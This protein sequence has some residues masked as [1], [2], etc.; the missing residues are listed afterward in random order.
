MSYKMEQTMRW[1][2]PNDP[3]SLRDILQSG[4]TGIVTAL[5]H[6][7]N[8]EVWSREEIKKRK[9]TIEAAG[10]TWS[11][12]ESV[13]VHEV[14][15][16]RSGNYQ[17][18]IE[19]YKETIRNLA[20]EGIYT[21]CYNFMPILDWT[22]TDL[23]REL[24]NGV[25]ALHYEKKAVQAFDLFILKRAEAEQEYSAEEKAE[26]QAYYEALSPE[27]HQ[28][29]IDNIL[30]GLPGSE[31]GYTMEEFKSM[32]KTYDGIDHAKLADHLRLFLDEIVPV[33]EENGVFMGIHPDDPPFSLF[34]LPRIMSTAAD[35]RRILTDQ[36]SPNNGLTF[37]TG[38][39]G[40]RADNDLPAMVRE[41][42]DHIHFIHLRSTKRDSE[43][44][45]FEDNHLEG[46]V[47]MVQVIEE[48]INLQEKRGK[49]L[50]MRPDHGHQMLDD[51]GKKTNPGYSAIGRLKGLA[52]IRGVEEA[53]LYMRSK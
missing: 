49:S 45:F 24:P 20:E 39:L 27:K 15:K 7:P 38:S 19:N 48:I 53:L 3:V 4:A 31:I 35:A 18:V 11:V 51:L 50:P 28:L 2:G 47:P 9:D 43:G 29:I 26:I 30:K 6:I 46:N 22:R 44:N 25:K 52:E 8:G 32:L 13:P 5:H 23:F 17:E 36:P 21:V 42:G 41:F 14:I 1:Y 12:V 33:A 37:C 34:G 16:T 10:L 40:V